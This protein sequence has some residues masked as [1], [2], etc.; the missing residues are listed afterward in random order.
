VGIYS[1]PEAARF[2]A[3]PAVTVTRWVK[4]YARRRHG[5]RVD[6]PALL[7]SSLDPIDGK[8]ALSFRDLMEVR[9]V[10]KLRSLGVAW[11]EIDRTVA[12]AREI[13]QTPY[14]F[15][16][17]VFK[18][19]GARVFAELEKGGPLL[20][21]GQFA[22]GVVFAPSLFAELEYEA[23][24]VARWRPGAGANVVVLDPQRSFGKPLL[25]EFDVQT[26]LVA[27]AVEAE[28]SVSRVAD[29]YEIPVHAVRTAVNYERQLLAA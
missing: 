26:R 21:D 11:S 9:F 29:W 2:A 25:D 17:L 23:G 15:G 12:T 6:Y 14:P 19:D 1:I 22:F 16:S 7:P 3:V 27:A 8:V 10:G 4:G 5:E 13:L 28:G 20:R 18:S 24:Q